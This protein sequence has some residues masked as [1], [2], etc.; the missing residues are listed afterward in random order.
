MFRTSAAHQAAGLC[1][2]CQQLCQNINTDQEGFAMAT[3][4][5]TD[6]FLRNSE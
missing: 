6:V 4:A 2:Q 5:S 3:E 1:R